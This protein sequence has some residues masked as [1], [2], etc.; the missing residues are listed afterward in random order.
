MDD[1]VEAAVAEL[2]AAI[3]EEVGKADQGEISCTQAKTDK[4]YPREFYRVG[5]SVTKPIA[6]TEA[7]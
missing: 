4:A 2:V 1:R 7:S 3:R 5:F 6:Q